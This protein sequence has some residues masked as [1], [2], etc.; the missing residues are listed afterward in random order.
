MA[1]QLPHRVY[2]VGG[3]RAFAM[4]ELVDAV[5]EMVA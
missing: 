3:G 2:N 5:K 4:E 1:E